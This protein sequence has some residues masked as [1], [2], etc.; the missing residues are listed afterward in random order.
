VDGLFRFVVTH[1][2]ATL[3][4]FAAA[5]VFG[6]VSYG[7]LPIELMPDISYPTLT[8]R[9][10]YEGA[11][12]EEV[13]TQVSQP[14]ESALATLDG[15][16]SIES[17]SRAGRSDVLLGFSWGTDMPG[18]AQAIR[19]NLQVTFLPQEAGRPLILRYDPSLDPFLR[20]ALSFGEEAATMSE[21]AKLYRLREVAD[22]VLRR[23]LEGMEGVAAVRIRGGLERE[24]RVEVREDWLAARRLRLEQVESALRSENVNVAGGSILEGDVEFLVRTL[25]EYSGVTDLRSVRIRRDDG[26]TVPLTEVAVLS[27]TH[28]ERQVVTHLDGAE[29]VEVEIFKEADANVVEVSKRVRAA[30]FGNGLPEVM[31]GDE[32]VAGELP[33]GVKLVVLDDQ[34]SFIEQAIDNLV[35]AAI[36]GGLLSIGVTFLFLRDYRATALIS[37]AI[38]LSVLMGFGPMYLWD[39]SLNLMSLGGLALGVGMVVDSAT[40]VL[41]SIQVYRDQGMSRQEAAIRG[42]SVIALAVTASTATTVAVFL[43]L[44]FVDGIAGELFGDL[45]IAVVASMVASLSVALLL[46]PTLAAIELPEAGPIEGEGLLAALAR[47]R[48][49][50]KVGVRALLSAVWHA[51]VDEPLATWREQRAWRRE[52]A[53]RR[54]W[55]PYAL[56]RLVTELLLRAVGVP[57]GLLVAL[58]LAISLTAGLT[59]IPGWVLLLVL[60]AGAVAGRRLWRIADRVMMA[61]A[62]AFYARY[63]RW[64]SR[65]DRMLAWSLRRPATVLFGAFGLFLISLAGAGTLA[66]ELIPEVHQGKFTIDTELPV[67]T[68][69]AVNLAAVSEAERIVSGHPDVET[70]Y[71]TIGADLRADAGSDEGEHTAKLRV[72]LTPGGDLAAREERVMDEL[73]ADLAALPRLAVRMERPAMFSFETPIEVVVYGY[74]LDDL[75]TA[76]DRV[77]AALRGVPELRD[78]RSSLTRG[79]PE[80]QIRYDRERLDRFGLDAATVADRVRDR[81]QGVE[82]TAIRRADKRIDLRVQLAESDR[83]TISDLR[84]INVNPSLIPPIPLDA[85]AEITE[86]EG[87]SEI[88]RVDQQRA[89]VIGAN[90]EGFDLGG[91]AA[92]IEGAL[93][94]VD[95]PADTTWVVAGQSEEMQR[96]TSSMW[97]ALWLAVFLV[98]VV[99]A[100]TFENLWHPFVILFSVPLALIGVVGGLLLTGLPVSV[101]VF[102]GLIT[103]AGVVVNNAIVLV[104]TVNRLRDDGMEP[105]EALAAAGSLRLRPILI[106]S[107]TTILG[108]VPL[109][110]GYGAGAEVQRPL[111]VAL[112]GGQTT[113]TFLTLLVVP[114][115]YAFMHQLTARRPAPEP[116][117]VVAK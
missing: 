17:R 91:A 55:A 104:D 114:A 35:D 77:V 48:A 88:R 30:L 85:V 25:N 115:V 116:D 106:T 73:R 36:L 29:A 70:V 113:S 2:V 19:E 41:E 109:A 63:D 57:V 97:F 56:F 101:V 96:S 99:M 112:M 100:A 9:T 87:P 18:A 26:V 40:V 110:L 13:E 74:G 5:V 20:V 12:P 76:G 11:A 44:G 68:P 108:V 81:V 107:I 98:Y 66:T 24:I 80:V 60:L 32:G 4:L 64:V 1:P 39:V 50:E 45:A 31:G 95:L 15:L 54:L 90:L 28:A 103:L 59:G 37:T 61:V 111:A 42:T 102:I 8:V 27:E 72:V 46:V 7:N 14:V 58:A 78:V 83:S 16:V 10:E 82:A 93:H 89:V 23:E 22:G 49:G 52:R 75:R 51:I 6:Q 65:Y 79:F 92:S 47:R 21:E 62:N 53:V 69:L 34:A 117:P 86:V 94:G 105:I 43:P 84:G 38:P 33:D 67:G 71:S 3:M